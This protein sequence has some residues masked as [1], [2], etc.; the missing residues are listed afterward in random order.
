MAPFGGAE[1]YK[2]VFPDDEDPSKS[3]NPVM[4]VG[5]KYIL[6]R[7]GGLLPWDEFK[8]VRPDVSKDEYMRYKA[9][10]FDNETD[11]NPLDGDIVLPT[12]VLKATT[13]GIHG[14]EVQFLGRSL[15]VNTALIPTAAAIGSTAYGA[16]RFGPK[17]GLATGLAGTAA[18]MLAGSALEN[19]RRRRNAEENNM[20]QIDRIY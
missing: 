10:R 18:G 5:A 16:R 8:K 20:N 13:D 19:E 1:G 14:P 2:A 7:T 9:F 6:G 11:L 15:P 17:G 4:E 3:T 12:G